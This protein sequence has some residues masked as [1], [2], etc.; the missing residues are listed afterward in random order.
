VWK[1]E[2]KRLLGERR[3]RWEGN[4]KMD[5]KQIVWEIVEWIHLAQVGDVVGSCENGNELSAS[6]KCGEFLDQLRTC[7]LSKKDSAARS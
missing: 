4:N 5:I 3:R 1:S 7:Q 6:I 2:R